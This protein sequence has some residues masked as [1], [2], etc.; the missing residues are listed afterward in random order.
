EFDRKG[1]SIAFA[2]SDPESASPRY[3]E[4]IPY[5]ATALR[6]LEDCYAVVGGA[7]RAS[8]SGIGLLRM[9]AGAEPEAIYPDPPDGES[10]FDGGGRVVRCLATHGMDSPPRVLIAAGQDLNRGVADTDLWELRPDGGV[11]HLGVI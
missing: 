8:A 4:V 9:R 3:V 7:P 1:T 11:A 6:L 2:L 10:V 5:C